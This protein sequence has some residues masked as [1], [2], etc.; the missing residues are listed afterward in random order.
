MQQLENHGYTLAGYFYLPPSSWLSFY[1]DL[2]KEFSA[3]LERHHHSEKAQE[4]I[5]SNKEEIALY[6]QYQDFYSYGFYIAQKSE[7]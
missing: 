5:Q 3:F 6:K 2:E 1:N 7:C 4:I